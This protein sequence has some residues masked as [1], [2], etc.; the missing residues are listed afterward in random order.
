M[1]PAYHLVFVDD[2]E[3]E[4][5]KIDY[6]MLRYFIDNRGYVLSAEQIYGSVWGN[7]RAEYIEEA[8]RSAIKRLRKKVGGQDSENVLIENVRDVGYRLPAKFER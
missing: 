5:T 8:V 7:E 2:A 3:V 1:Y 4:L 6:D